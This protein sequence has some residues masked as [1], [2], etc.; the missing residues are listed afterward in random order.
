MK[1]VVLKKLVLIL[2]V[3][4]ITQ[5]KISLLNFGNIMANTIQSWRDI[6]MTLRF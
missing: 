5:I 2:S 3:S 1:D 4:N 6:S